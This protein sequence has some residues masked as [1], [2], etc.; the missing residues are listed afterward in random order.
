[1]SSQ[2]AIIV[3]GGIGGLAAAR[4]FQRKGIQV[5]LLEKAAAFLPTTGAGFGFS[6]NG[7]LCVESLGLKD[8][9]TPILHPFRRHR[10]TTAN[11]E[12]IYDGDQLDKLGA[13][14]GYYLSGTMRADLV[15]LLAN[16]LEQDTI[17]YKSNVTAIHQ[18]ETSVQVTLANGETFKGDFLVGA[19]G[20]SSIVARTVI[21]TTLDAPVYCGENM[22]YGILDSIP[23]FGHAGEMAQHLEAG[24]Y[25]Q[26][27]IGPTKFVWAQ[28]YKGEAPPDQSEWTKGNT[29]EASLRAFLST[30]S[31][32]H[33]LH[34]A[35]AITSPDRLLHFGLYYR[36]PKPSWHK[37]RVVLLGDAC[38]ATL[39]HFGQGAN[40]AMEDAVVLADAI[41]T[42]GTKDLPTAFD[43]YFQKRFDRTKRVVDMAWYLGKFKQMDGLVGRVVRNATLRYA[44][45]SG[46][47]MRTAFKEIVEHCPIPLPKKPKQP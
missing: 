18:D 27:P 45:E 40:Q 10:V 43:A 41:A 21:D 44:L 6:A 15:S 39:P 20:V 35:V 33:P 24:E 7:Q 5:T 3:G 14:I 30:L 16:S 12:L 25:I 28:V 1:M 26:F 38:H 34:A 32:S 29:P 37:G 13:D 47:L 46:V 42:H 9:L 19:D 11:N 8:A 22:F 36:K 23:A 2:R 31:P 17:H 4:A